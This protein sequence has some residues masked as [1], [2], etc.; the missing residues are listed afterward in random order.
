MTPG[1]FAGTLVVIVAIGHI[2]R[3]LLDRGIVTSSGQNTDPSDDSE[4]PDRS[5]D[6][7]DAAVAAYVLSGA[8]GTPCR[9][10]RDSATATAIEIIVDGNAQITRR[11][12]DNIVL[13]LD[14]SG[15]GTQNPRHRQLVLEHLRSRSWRPSR[16]ADLRRSVSSGTL[17]ANPPGRLWWARFRGAVADAAFEAGLTRRRLPIIPLRALIAVGAIVTAIAA[18]HTAIVLFALDPSRLNLWLIA[19]GL[20]AA[21]LTVDALFMSI[22]RSDLLTGRGRSLAVRVARRVDE[23]ANSTDP[24][25][26]ADVA[27]PLAVAV[28]VATRAARQVAI[29]PPAHDRRIWS[30]ASGTPRVVRV[31]RRFMPADGA[32]PGRVAIGGVSAV[33]AGVIIRRVVSSI[34][35]A[36]WIT[37]LESAVPDAFG[38]L[39]QHL[40]AVAALALVPIVMG[41]LAAIVGVIDLAVTREITGVVI[42]VRLPS[43]RRFIDRLRASMSGAGHDGTAVVELAVDDGS[44]AVVRPLLVDARAAAPVGATVLIRRTALL[45]RVRSLGPT[46]TSGAV[47]ASAPNVAS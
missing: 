31:A 42:D 4:A 11:Q 44:S 19:A 15:H 45:A 3:W 9:V 12:G 14:E 13:E 41:T 43:D 46:G 37:E 47:A 32:R 23:S 7:V 8:E 25:L 38:P 33:V 5:V 18:L 35:G 36:S 29:N 6:D 1:A 16:D 21:Q 20:G 26:D 24:A 2:V 39:D 17:V 40:D 28:G 10:L 22:E 30:T 34:R 27:P